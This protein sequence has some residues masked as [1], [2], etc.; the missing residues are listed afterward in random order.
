MIP[1]QYFIYSETGTTL[2][3]ISDT[4]V[5]PPLGPEVELRTSPSISND[6]II[7]ATKVETVTS[8]KDTEDIANSSL[9]I[10]LNLAPV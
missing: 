6:S 9:L 1:P 4:L 3:V 7:L 5:G 8:P 2:Y 10:H